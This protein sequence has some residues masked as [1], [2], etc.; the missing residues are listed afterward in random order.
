MAYWSDLGPTW[1]V[2]FFL[3]LE[4]VHPDD[5][6]GRDTE[7][8][9]HWHV[10]EA[11][12]D[13]SS[14]LDANWDVEGADREAMDEAVHVM[15]DRHCRVEEVVSRMLVAFVVSESVGPTVGVLLVVDW[16]L[17]TDES[18]AVE[19][20][21]HGVDNWDDVPIDLVDGVVLLNVHAGAA[22]CCN[23]AHWKVVVAAVDF[24]TNVGDNSLTF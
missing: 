11:G 10:E 23:N 20:L 17:K 9:N 19:V 3:N 6:E 5:G 16:V 21:I 12:R 8:W 18:W 14:F 7:I 15:D 4:V 22:D 24:V 13:A 1:A 2:P